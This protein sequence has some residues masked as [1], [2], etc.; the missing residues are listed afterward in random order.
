MLL[1]ALP[2]AVFYAVTTVRPLFADR[3]LIVVTP[4]LYLL[5]AGGILALE[6]RARPLAPVALALILATAWVP[7]RD[8]N[9]ARTG[10]AQKEDWRGAYA[11]IAAH[12]HPNDLILVHPGYLRTTL[13]YYRLRGLGG[14]RL[15]DVPVRTIPAEATAVAGDAYDKRGFELALERATA[16]FERVWLVVSEDRLGPAIDPK[17]LVRGE[18]FQ[19]NSRLLEERRFNGVWLGLYTYNGQG[20][21]YYPP[22]PV[23]LDVTFGAGRDAATLLGYGYDFAPSENAVRPGG[24]VPLVLRWRFPDRQAGPF[25]LRWHLLDEGGNRVPDAGGAEPLLGGRALRPWDRL[26]QVWDYHDLPLPADLGPGR[27]RVVIEVVATERPEAPLPAARDGRV[28]PEGG[29]PLGWIEV[30]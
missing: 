5:A 21:P 11:R 17:D 15:R 14:G 20:L 4:A 13:D 28:L 16:G 19:Y 12:A 1:V 26:D 10:A 25:G 3:Y 6:R 7:L 8:V 29:V 27:Y 30:R 2:L 24:H 23:T 18:W 9:L 22:V